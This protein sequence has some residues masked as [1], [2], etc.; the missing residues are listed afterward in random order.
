MRTNHPKIVEIKFILSIPLN[1]AFEITTRT[2]K[3]CSKSNNK[4]TVFNA[5][6][7]TWYVSS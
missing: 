6:I 1:A 7:S 2:N 4:K 5:P 3:D